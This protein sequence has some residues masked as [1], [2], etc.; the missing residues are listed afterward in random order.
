[1]TELSDVNGLGR[2]GPQTGLTDLGSAGR[3]S[4]WLIVIFSLSTIHTIV[5]IFAEGKNW[6]AFAEGAN[7][8][9]IAIIPH[10]PIPG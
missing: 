10:G 9:D 5:H 8:I 1:M 3:F 4:T 6:F 2:L 7:A